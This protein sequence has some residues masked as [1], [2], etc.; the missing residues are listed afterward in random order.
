MQELVTL[1]V[2]DR[3]DGKDGIE[4]ERVGIG[5]NERNIRDAVGRG[6]YQPCNLLEVPALALQ[7]IL[8]LR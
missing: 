7:C 2:H 6:G 1:R 3:F 5:G 4:I 8:V